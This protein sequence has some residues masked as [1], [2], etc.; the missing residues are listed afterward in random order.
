MNWDG[1]VPKKPARVF[2]QVCYIALNQIGRANPRSACETESNDGG[3]GPALMSARGT[4]CLPECMPPRVAV[5]RTAADLLHRASGL[6]AQ[7]NGVRS[8]NQLVTIPRPEG[9]GFLAREGKMDSEP[10]LKAIIAAMM[11]LEHSGPDEIDPDSAVKC[12]ENMSYELLQLAGS[13]RREFLE[14]IERIANQMPEE[15]QRGF[16]RDIPRMTGMVE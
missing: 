6:G 7:I 13:D 10:L 11:F 4:S 5:P 12:L 9:R 14:L 2:P 1:H 8:D 3:D 15:R 16:I